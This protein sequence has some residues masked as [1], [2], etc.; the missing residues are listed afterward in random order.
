MPTDGQGKSI[1][2][3]MSG[4]TA[5]SFVRLCRT[6]FPVG[7]EY[8][9]GG[10]HDILKL[11]LPSLEDC[12]AACAFYNQRYQTKTDK[13]VPV[14]G[15]LCR[16]VTIVKKAGGHCYLKNGTANNYAKEAD[17]DLTSSAVILAF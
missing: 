8:G 2:V 7:K 13:G 3:K 5:Q 9:N 10:I 4:G 16:S 11:Y 15:G 17:P 14:A 6:D 12:I 1:P